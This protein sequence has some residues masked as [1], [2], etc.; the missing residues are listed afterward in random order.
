MTEETIITQ[1]YLKKILHYDPDTG[2]WVWLISVPGRKKG[3]PAGGRRPDGYGRISINNKRYL[4]HRLSFLYMTGEFPEEEV[5]HRDGNPFNDKWD[6]LRAVSH[7]ENMRNSC[8]RKRNKLGVKGVKKHVSG[9]YI[10]YIC[11]DKIIYEKWFK[12]LEHAKN[13]REEKE[14]ELFGEFRRIIPK[15]VSTTE[16]QD[17]HSST[18]GWR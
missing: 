13:W 4:M 10:G 3:E 18:R 15:T 2:D 14:I 7:S 16:T 9:G 12:E 8:V 1:E 17:S 11:K 6:N 5:D